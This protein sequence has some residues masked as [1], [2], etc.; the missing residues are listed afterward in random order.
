MK[1]TYGDKP[2]R[3]EPVAYI[4]ADGD[5]RIKNPTSAT[6]VSVIFFADSTTIGAA[7][8]SPDSPHNRRVFYP[9]DSITIT[10]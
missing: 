10:F 8:F 2:D 4:D 7:D 5:L 3:G 9:G 6:G 1:F